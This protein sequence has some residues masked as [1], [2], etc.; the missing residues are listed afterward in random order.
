MIIVWYIAASLAGWLLVTG[1]LPALEPSDTEMIEVAKS[2]G[3]IQCKEDSGIS[4]SEMQ[5]TLTNEGI[6]IIS[7]R[8]SHDCLFRASV[9]GQTTGSV[10]VYRIK[11]DKFVAAR[12]LGFSP[13]RDC[14]NN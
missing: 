7:S 4:L 6:E 11:K 8:R 9:C 13:F 12:S 10:N 14:H 2:D 1:A 5:L 3:S